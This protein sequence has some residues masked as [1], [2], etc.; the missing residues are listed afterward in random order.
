MKRRRFLAMS[1]TYYGERTPP[2]H[3]IK[4]LDMWSGQYFETARKPWVRGMW[5]LPR[6]MMPVLSISSVNHGS[7]SKTHY[8]MFRLRGWTFSVPLA[9]LY[10]HSR[11]VV[12]KRPRIQFR[13]FGIA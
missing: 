7:G 1:G 11:G 5:I 2:V 9:A 10:L 12:P 13:W 8:L 3:V 4:Y 6:L